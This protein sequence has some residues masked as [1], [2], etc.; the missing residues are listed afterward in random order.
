MW[1][2]LSQFEAPTK[3]GLEWKPYYGN[4]N[5]DGFICV[6]NR[7]VLQKEGIKFAPIDVAKHF[8][9]EIEIEEN[10]GIETFAY[11]FPY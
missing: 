7:D 3:L 6:H 4:T 2:T 5:E 9:K 10:K 11:H 8:S 1:E